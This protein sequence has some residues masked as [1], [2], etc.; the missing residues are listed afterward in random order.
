MCVTS[1][2][3]TSDGVAAAD[4]EVASSWRSFAVADSRSA[5]IARSASLRRRRWRL[6]PIQ[7]RTSA[8]M[9]LTGPP[10]GGRVVVDRELPPRLLVEEKGN[11][12]GRDGRVRRSDAE[13]D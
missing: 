12:G 9:R 2:R 6:Q 4:N 10:P 8:T 13:E 5:S 7:T 3:A 11:P 1:E